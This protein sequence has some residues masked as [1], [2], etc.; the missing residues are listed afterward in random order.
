MTDSLR[1]TIDSL[2]HYFVVARST[3]PETNIWNSYPRRREA[4]A[5]CRRKI[6]SSGK[7]RIYVLSGLKVESRRVHFNALVEPPGTPRLFESAKYFWSREHPSYSPKKAYYLNSK[8]SQ[9]IWRIKEWFHRRPNALKISQSYLDTWMRALL[10]I[11]RE[12]VNKLLINF[13]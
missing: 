12:L 1:N 13:M 7:R 6:S 5:S 11:Y 4:V 3:P 2:I 8:P 9:N 10:Q